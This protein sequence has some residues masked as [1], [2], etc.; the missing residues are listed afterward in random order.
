MKKFFTAFLLVFAILAAVAA[1]G[2]AAYKYGERQTVEQDRLRFYERIS[3]FEKQQEVDCFNEHFSLE[4]R[5]VGWYFFRFDGNLY[6]ACEYFAFEGVEKV[7]SADVINLGGWFEGMQGGEELSCLAEDRNFIMSYTAP[8]G[9]KVAEL[10]LKVEDTGVSVTNLATGETYVQDN[11]FDD[12]IPPV[13]LSALNPEEPLPVKDKQLVYHLKGTPYVGGAVTL[14]YDTDSIEVDT[15]AEWL[16]ESYVVPTEDGFFVLCTLCYS[17]DWRDTALVRWTENGGFKLIERYE[18]G[19][20]GIEE[21]SVEENTVK[22]WSR[23]N[24]F[25]TYGYSRTYTIG[26]KGLTALSPVYDFE[27]N[28]QPQLM[29]EIY[30]A[31][32]TEESRQHALMIYDGQ[33][34]RKLVVKQEIVCSNDKGEEVQLRKDT[35][36]YPTGIDPEK[37]IFYFEYEGENCSFSY[38]IDEETWTYSANGISEKKLFEA[39]FY[40]G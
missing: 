1:G 5:V 27:N 38:L 17:N 33:G 29:Q 30:S 11:D 20:G 28:P 7:L 36:I 32:Y 14:S 19:V 8:N 9:E 24:V 31:G 6:I 23:I 37:Q 15:F 18:G 39:V 4:Q 12:Y 26:E 40:A 3:N 34:R 10:M 35:N 16:G 13:V 22:L 2:Y 21:I 25:G